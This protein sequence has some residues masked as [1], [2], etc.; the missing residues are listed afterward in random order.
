MTGAVNEWVLV[1]K[2]HFMRVDYVSVILLFLILL[3]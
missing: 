2:A 1:N 3:T